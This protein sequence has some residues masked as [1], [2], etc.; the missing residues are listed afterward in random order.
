M[1]LTRAR[2][3]AGDER[4]GLQVSDAIA[5]IVRAKRDPAHV[6]KKVRAMRELIAQEKGDDDPWDLKLARGGLTDL[7]FIAQG[8]TLAH[9]ADR[10]T[11]IGLQPE[12]LFDR[13]AASGLVSQNDTRVLIEAC[14]VFHT[15]FQWQRLTIDG[16]FVPNSVPRPIFKRLAAALGLP[17]ERI[18]IDY[19]NGIRFNVTEVYGRVSGD[20]PVKRPPHNATA[21]KGPLTCSCSCI[22]SLTRLLVC[23]PGYDTL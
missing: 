19:L 9:A 22:L 10:P 11:L 14:G 6:F 13:A 23:C 2:V 5:A 18:L 4:F 1:A 3:L 21:V 15:L 20:R 7:D 12:V 16:P 8:L 17:D